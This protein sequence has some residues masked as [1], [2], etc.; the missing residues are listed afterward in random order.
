MFLTLHL[1]ANAVLTLTYHPELM[2]NPSGTE[3]P[4]RSSLQRSVNLSLASAR[5]TTECLVYADLCSSSAYVSGS[6]PFMLFDT[7]ILT[8]L[9][10]AQTSAP[11]VVQPIYVAALAFL[12]EVKL[13][14]FHGNGNGGQDNE[15]RT[16][17]AQ[18]KGSH[19]APNNERGNTEAFLA[20]LHKQ[21]LTTLSRALQRIEVYWAGCA[22]A[23]NI[24]AQ[25]ESGTSL[26]S[27]G[28]FHRAD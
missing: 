13:E 3:T 11:L 26:E 17:Q 25:R 5:L 22:Y 7:C 23:T 8:V 15:T 14:A 28:L 9:G 1:W 27:I 18:S 21:S 10:L 12:H 4:F 24:L 20:S 2:T 6:A 16:N 19:A